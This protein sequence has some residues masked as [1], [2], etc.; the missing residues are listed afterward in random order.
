M[1]LRIALKS[2]HRGR[3]CD[4]QVDVGAHS[5][6]DGRRNVIV[7]LYCDGLRCNG[8]HTRLICEEEW[9]QFL[10]NR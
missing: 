7:I 5:S 3:S 1:R 9:V 2:D 10:P 4:I 6:I 8:M